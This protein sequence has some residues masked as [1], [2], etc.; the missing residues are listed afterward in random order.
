MK[1]DPND[2]CPCGSTKK[3]GD[4]CMQRDA[5]R[6]TGDEQVRIVGSGK[7]GDPKRLE[8]LPG[9]LLPGS[10]TWAECHRT[11]KCGHE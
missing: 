4:C 9:A 7:P 5:D 11:P 10:H 2:P 8:F 6:D 1:T 3:Y